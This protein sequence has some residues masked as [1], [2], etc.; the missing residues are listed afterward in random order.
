MKRPLAVAFLALALGCERK[1][2]R[3]GEVT[4]LVNA[5]AAFQQARAEGKPVFL[6]FWSDN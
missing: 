2:G 5:D 6:E 3:I 1:P 4:F